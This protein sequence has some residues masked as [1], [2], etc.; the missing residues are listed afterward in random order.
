MLVVIVVVFVVAMPKQAR[1]DVQQGGLLGRGSVLKSELESNGSNNIKVCVRVRPFV[2]REER[3]TCVIKMPNKNEVLIDQ[4]D[5]VKR[6]QFDRAY[7][8]HQPSDPTFASQQTLM[9]EL[10]NDIL[11]NAM[12]GF[13]NCLLAYGQTGSG[14]THSVLGGEGE[15]RGLLPRVLESLFEKLDIAVDDGWSFSCK[16]S[17]LEIYNENVHDLLMPNNERGKPLQVHHNPK[18]GVYVPEITECVVKNYTEV[19]KLIRFGQKSRMVAATN[20]NNASSR[21]HC[22]FT[23]H[24]E[25]EK[26]TGALQ[27]IA[28]AQVNLVDLAGSE[29]QSMS[30]CEGERL[31]E[32]AMINQSLSALAAVINKL[33]SNSGK[34]SQ[35]FVPFRNSKLTMLLQESLSGNSK[36][37]LIAAISPAKSNEEASL[38]TLRFAQTCKKITTKVHQNVEKRQSVFSGMKDEIEKLR[39]QLAAGEWRVGNPDADSDSDESSDSADSRVE[40]KELEELRERLA[41][42]KEQIEKWEQRRALA[43]EDIG[44]GLSISNITSTYQVDPDTPQLVNLSNDPSLTGCLVYYI[45][46][47]QTT[48][49]GSDSRCKVLLKGLGIKE[50]MFSLQNVDNESVH[51]K[52]LTADGEELTPEGLKDAMR[53]I[54]RRASGAPGRVLINGR[55][56]PCVAADLNHNDRIFVGHAYCFRLSIPKGSPPMEP[57]LSSHI[58]Y[59]MEDTLFDVLHEHSD[60]FMECQALMESLKDRIGRQNAENFL[61]LFG[62]TLPLVEEANLITSNVRPNEGLRFQLE[63][64]SDILRFTIDE[65]ELIVRLFKADAAN[66]ANNRPAKETPLIA[67]ELPEFEDRLTRMR[68]ICDSFASGAEDKLDPWED[69]WQTLGFFELREIMLKASSQRMEEAQATRK[70]LRKRG[71]MRWSS[72][73]SVAATT[74]MVSTKSVKNT[75]IKDCAMNASKLTTKLLDALQGIQTDIRIR[76]TELEMLLI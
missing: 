34:A 66:E 32:G 39:A 51:L 58:A 62:R 76:E 15:S 38:S 48:I 16:A 41:E 45:P 42:E 60:E 57:K 2:P 30:R 44:L 55:Q 67:M 46:Q 14:K 36:T 21:S 18:I 22:I 50:F 23:F 61:H 27:D 40:R 70:T 68:E 31:R 47:N 6:F 56:P 24:L 7:W 9:Y 73:D 63:I 13:N 11:I 71:T 20:M 29:R 35:E 43:L 37:V 12:Q 53:P 64:A 19:E 8:S 1:F 74:S 26:D 49:V 25:K 10:G 65:P 59:S 28:R 72:S 4:G 75:R 52:L 54:S 17:Y 69:P 5:S 3:E 33:A